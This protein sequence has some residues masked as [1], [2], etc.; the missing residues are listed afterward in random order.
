MASGGARRGPGMIN[1]CMHGKEAIVQEVL[2]WKPNVLLTTRSVMPMPD[3]PKIVITDR[4]TALPNGG[5]QVDVRLAKPKPKER[6]K[7][8]ELREMLVG[9]IQASATAIH[10]LAEAKLREGG[11]GM[12]QPALPK[13]VGRFISE[14]VLSS[15]PARR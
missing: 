2:D 7:F 8:E 10:D 14:P 9:M 11:G 12:D 4:L 3:S 15:E 13:S 5:T 1:H 6:A